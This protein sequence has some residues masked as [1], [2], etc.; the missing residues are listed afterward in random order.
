MAWLLGEPWVSAPSLRCLLGGLALGR[1]RGVGPCPVDLALRLRP[2]L[3]KL[4][5]EIHTVLTS[6]NPGMELVYKDLDN[7][8]DMLFQ[9]AAVFGDLFGA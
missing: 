9:E 3:G 6:D 5:R 8:I 7:V 2:E 4:Q 1:T